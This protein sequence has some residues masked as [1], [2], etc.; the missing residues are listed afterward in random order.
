[1]TARIETNKDE[2]FQK[3]QNRDVGRETQRAVFRGIRERKHLGKI[4]LEF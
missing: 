4:M 3:V 1:M 2:R